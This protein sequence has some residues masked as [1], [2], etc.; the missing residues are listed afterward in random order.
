MKKR[1]AILMTVHNRKDKTLMCLNSL[2][3]C[4]LTNEYE[5]DVYIVNDGCTDGTEY[6][7]IQKFPK[8]IIIQ[9][10]GNLF[11]NRGMRLAWQT[12]AS[13][14][15]YDYF[16]WLNDD[17]ILFENAIA[18]ILKCSELKDNMAIISG[19]TCSTNDIKTITYGGRIRRVGIVKPNGEMQNCDC[20]NGQICLIPKAVYDKMGINDPIFHHGFGDWDYGFRAKKKGF[21]II[22]APNVSGYCDIN[23]NDSSPRYLNPDISVLKRF[24]I[25]Y[26]P[27]GKNPLQFFIYTYRHK[28]LL[29][30]IISILKQHYSVILLHKNK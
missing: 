19:S 27:L 29:T 1:I 2:Y 26:S 17:V 16:I 9:G 3:K 20:C 4:I 7:I 23:T 21:E 18:E 25:L 8:V 10:N 6:A 14:Y 15:K 13:T 30:A 5:L 12:A 28:S 22:V 11:W 24:K